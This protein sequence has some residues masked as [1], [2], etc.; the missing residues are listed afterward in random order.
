[1]GT[2]NLTGVLEATMRDPSTRGPGARL[3]YGLQDQGND[4]VGRQART[5]FAPGRRPHQGTLGLTRIFDAID[6]AVVSAPMWGHDGAVRSIAA[7]SIDGVPVIVSVASTVD[8]AVRPGFDAGD[9]RTPG[10][11][12]GRCPHRLGWSRRSP[13]PDRVRWE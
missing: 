4:G 6:G 3:N 9:R 5:I 10:G 2:E 1:M 13:A 11:A 7:T 8:V 12:D